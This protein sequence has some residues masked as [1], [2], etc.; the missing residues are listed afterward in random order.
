MEGLK[1]ILLWVLLCLFSITAR[2]VTYYVDGD[3]GDDAW[4]GRFD[5]Y[6]SGSNGP[7]KTIGA[8]LSIAADLD[9]IQITGGAY[10]E[11][12]TINKNLNFAIAGNISVRCL[13]MNGVG[14]RLFLGGSELIVT[15]TLRLTR[16]VIDASIANLVTGTNCKVP[17]GSSLSFVEGKLFRS[18]SATSVTDLFFPIGTGGDYRPVWM[19]FQQSTS[20]VNRY[21]AQV[22]L[23]A[24]APVGL[25]VGIKN[26]SKVH[27]WNL[28][29]TGTAVPSKYLLRL[30][31]DSAKN[32]DEVFDP[33]RLRLVI[34]YPG[35]PVFKNLGGNGTAR[36]R[37]NITAAITTDTLGNVT[38]ANAVL[39]T[40][41]L[42]RREPSPKFTW[43]GNCEGA[44][45]QFTDSSFSFKSTINK[46]RWDFGT[47]NPS[48]TSILKNPKFTFSGTGPFIVTL[49]VTN[50]LGLF[51]SVTR[52]LFLRPKPKAALSGS[53][54]CFGNVQ[55]FTDLSTATSPDTIKSRTWFLGDGNTRINKIVSHKYALP[56]KYNLRLAV[57]SSSG[58]SDTA[59]RT[60][61]VFS[62][63]S[64]VMNVQR[65][66]LGDTTLFS[67]T[68]GVAGDSIVNWEWFVTGASQSTLKSFKRKFSAEGN[69]PLMLTV[70]SQNNC[71]D[72]ARQTLTIFKGPVATFSL[73]AAVPGNDS[74]QCF[75]GNKF[76]LKSMA[77]AGQGQV[78]NNFWYW[79]NAT[80]PGSNVQSKSAGGQTKAKL[81]AV[82]DKGCRDSAEK[83]YVVRDPINIK[84]GVATFCLPKAAEFDDSS[85]AGTAAITQRNW[86]FGDGG[87]STGT[88]VTHAFG[89][90]GVY[91]VKLVIRT[92]EGCADS[93]TNPV[94]L[95][96]T[97]AL[98]I[99]DITGMPICSGDSVRVRA[100]GGFNVR[101]FDGDTNRTRHFKTPGFRSVTAY[102]SPF[103][104]KT[105]SLR[106]DVNPPVFADAGRDTSLVRGRYIILKGDG[107]QKYRW[108][109][110][111]LCDNPDSV[112]TRVRPQ[113]TTVF[114]LDVTDING[115]TG[116]DSVK[117]TVTEPLFIRIPNMITPNGDGKND[118]W[119][120]REVPYVETG[121]I[122][123]FNHL[124]ELVYEQN[125]GYN[126]TWA[127][128]SSSGTPLKAG[129]YLYV[130]EVPTE[131][132]PFKGYLQI[133]P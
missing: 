116:L 12:I 100:N 19:T 118:A 22:S 4:N 86:D 36:F 20:A 133:M 16:G 47:G 58:C 7:K 79:D 103:C 5:S 52:I 55:T 21:I 31:Y 110:R 73:D 11:C 1:R 59:K 53:D 131:K 8:A 49:T 50:T 91:N 84:Y 48:D 62:K 107:G 114:Y 37:G 60:I 132:E 35:S 126:H 109:P 41:T 93:L 75:K 95:T 77:A 2:A 121:R 28:R 45:I 34:K 25:P 18:N 128:T 10:N 66:C 106:I 127:G 72:T 85:S 87:K 101:W 3:F 89:G 90:G 63:P 117:V 83:T 33:V 65:I 82:T 39:G 119:D 98:N 71:R 9:V 43:T 120:L 102:N 64:P 124:G 74:L 70:V 46:W 29:H 94:T 105:D 96:S 32:D 54:A 112:R 23:A 67:G 104:F 13:I 68:G 88:K 113:Q 122:T 92:N 61:N 51:D 27:F 97:P 108:T 115:C 81:V 15:D 80:V 130:I 14:K 30:A 38:L 111:A 42:G 78:V 17:A 123:I 24:L 129:A 69:Y 99:V 40:N 56:G 26:I 57:V 6:S 125:T 44:P 76:T